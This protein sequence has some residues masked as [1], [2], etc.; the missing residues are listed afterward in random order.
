MPNN[1]AHLL[2]RFTATE[3]QRRSSYILDAADICPVIITR[4]SE[5]FVLMSE[6]NYRD[7]VRLTKESS[8]A[9]Q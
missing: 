4:N 3:L 8:D 5:G 6:Q 2:Q 7:L 9:R 1:I